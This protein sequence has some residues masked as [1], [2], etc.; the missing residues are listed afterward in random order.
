MAHK[1]RL[2]MWAQFFFQ[3]H[4][5]GVSLLEEWEMGQEG[6][7]APGGAEMVPP[8]KIRD[9]E[10]QPQCLTQSESSV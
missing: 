7:S 1:E 3:T 9:R 5:L 8:P 2:V 4:Q 10:R 6:Q